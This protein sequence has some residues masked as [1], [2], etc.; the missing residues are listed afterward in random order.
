MCR[1]SS[2]LAVLLHHI[3]MPSEPEALWILGLLTS[4]L[5]RL[6]P[7][8]VTLEI[9]IYS[10][11]QTGRVSDWLTWKTRVPLPL[12]RWH[13]GA[14]LGPQK[15]GPQK[16]YASHLLLEARNTTPSQALLPWMHYQRQVVAGHTAQISPLFSPSCQPHC[17][18]GAR[19]AVK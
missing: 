4:R 11:L 5:S 7:R 16:S 18:Q 19:K 1:R 12:A 8:R 15:P 9:V 2:K 17:D 13:K 6:P 10:R 14:S 3:G